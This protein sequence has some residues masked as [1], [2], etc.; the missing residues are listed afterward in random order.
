MSFH[1]ARLAHCDTCWLRAVLGDAPFFRALSLFLHRYEFK[2][3]DTHDLM[4]TLKDATGR[5]TVG[6]FR[7]RA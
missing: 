2:S 3:A 7:E 6:P 4:G 5:N 1:Y